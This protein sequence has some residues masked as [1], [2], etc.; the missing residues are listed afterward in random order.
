LKVLLRGGVA[1]ESS[2]AALTIER[3]LPQGHVAAVLG[4]ARACG[5]PGWFAL[6]LTPP[7][8]T[9]LGK[10]HGA[11]HSARKLKWVCI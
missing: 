2:Q 6:T 8:N 9:P 4:T 11:T 10:P 5:V 1:V 3:R 7:S